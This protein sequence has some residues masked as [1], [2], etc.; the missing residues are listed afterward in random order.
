[1]FINIIN[2]SEEARWLTNPKRNAAV[3]VAPG[4]ATGEE[5]LFGCPEC[6][7]EQAF[8][9]INPGNR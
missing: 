3:K 2:T 6:D 5:N 9:G 7:A 4:Y 1:L 8:R